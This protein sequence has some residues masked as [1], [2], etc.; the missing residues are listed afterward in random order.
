M[1]LAVPA[2]RLAAIVDDVAPR[3]AA[4]ARRIPVASAAVVA[5]ALP[6][7]TPLPEQSGVLVATD[8]RG[9]CTPRRSRCPAAN[10]AG[11][12][13]S[14]WCGCPSAGSATSMARSVGDDELSLGGG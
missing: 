10:G 5:L 2:P 11:A 6:G 8:E 1:V 13:T 14:N 9:R 3:T 4:A 7:G 12:A